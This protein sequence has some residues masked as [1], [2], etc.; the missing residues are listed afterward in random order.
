MLML[1]EVIAIAARQ[2]RQIY[3]GIA[4]RVIAQACAIA[5]FFL[6]W[7]ALCGLLQGE[8]GDGIWLWLAMAACLIGQLLFSHWGQ[9]DCFVGAYDLMKHYRIALIGHLYRMPLGFFQQRRLGTLTA[10]LI[11]DV[12]C[13][14]EIFTH[15]IAEVVVG[16]SVPLLF[17]LALM[18][19]DWRLSLA[20]LIPLPL[21]WLLNQNFCHILQ[22]KAERQSA[23]LAKAS[24]QLVEFIGAIVTL[25]LFDRHEAFLTNL[26]EAFAQIRQASLGIEVWGGGGVQ[27]L[28][29][30]IELGLV[31]LVLMAAWL[32]DSQRLDQAT[33]LLFVLVAYKIVDSLLDVSAYLTQLRMMSLAATRLNALMAL[34]A[35]PQGS[36]DAPEDVSLAFDQ[37]SFAYDEEPV[38]RDVSFSVPAGSITAIVGPS[39]SGKSTL[40]HLLGRFYDPQQG[41]ITL[42]GIDL[43]ELRSE[44]LYQTLGFVFQDVQLFD[45]SVLDNVRVGCP[46]A[47]EE[48]VRQAYR[49]ACCEAFIKQLDEGDHSRLGE[50]GQRLSG[51]ERQRLSIARMML[52]KPRVVLLDE[53]TASIDP[54]AQRDIQRGLSRLAQGRTVVM[55]AHRLRTVEHVDQILVLDHGTIVESGNHQ[56]LL[57]LDGLYKRLWDEQNRSDKEVCI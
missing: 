57:A 28:R 50:G 14:E 55:I 12:K 17:M 30:M 6:A 1:H 29:L 7:L 22:Q 10:S 24:G 13:V 37:V 15:L 5:P 47:S 31:L 48:A 52:M 27:L 8:S 46:Q 25:R 45:G 19:I 2:P 54:N 40:L 44:A 51:G 43:R 34:P 20:L 3:R 38:L 32:F 39:G 41:R 11:D 42:G 53:A 18:C 21:G 36:H 56:Q 9:L 49:D 33:W 35:Q 16:L 23:R 26:R 4:L